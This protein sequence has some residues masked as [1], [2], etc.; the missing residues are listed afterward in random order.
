MVTRFQDGRFVVRGDKWEQAGGFPLFRVVRGDNVGNPNEAAQRAAAHVKQLLAPIAPDLDVE[1]LIIF[2]S[3]RAN[4]EVS[5][6]V[7]PVLHTDDK[8][9]PNLKDYMRELAQ[10]QKQNVA[11][12]QASKKKGKPKQETGFVIAPDKIEALARTFEEATFPSKLRKSLAES[13]E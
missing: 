4:L 8:H 3:P 9:E 1:P 7:V 12:Q 13:N 2:V 10:Q 11:E 6:P 5:N